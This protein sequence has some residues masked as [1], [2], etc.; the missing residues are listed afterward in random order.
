M[1]EHYD[2]LRTEPLR[3]DDAAKPNGSI[4]DHGDLLATAYACCGCG[5]MSGAH[6]IG[7]GE[8]R[9]DQSIILAHWQLIECAVGERDANGFRLCSADHADAEVASVRAS[10]LQ[11]LVAEVARAIR[12][13]ERHDHQVTS[14]DSV[15]IGADGFHDA[16]CFMPH[17]SAA[18]N[19]FKLLVG[20]EI[21][22]A[23]AGTR[24][25]NDGI[26]WVHELGVRH[27]LNPD[28]SR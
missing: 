21:A 5:V 18:G 28:V 2:L 1:T 6:D 3:S 17:G 12:E 13:C 15:N 19:G 4:A 25:A 26:G 16:D 8:K 23:D 9:W 7:K 20:P 14:F 10:C 22:S 11:T 27:F 24:D